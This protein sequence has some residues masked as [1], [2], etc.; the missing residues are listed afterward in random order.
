MTG[1]FAIMH[2]LQNAL[3]CLVLWL[4]LSGTGLLSAC[5]SDDDGWKAELAA[6]QKAL[7]LQQERLET[8]EDRAVVTGI[9]LTDEGYVADFSDGSCLTLLAASGNPALVTVGNDNLWSINGTATPVPAAGETE[10]EAP[11][12]AVGADGNW[13]LD[14][15]NTGLHA[16]VRHD[17]GSAPELWG[18]VET[19]GSYAFSFSDG[20]Q[21]LIRREQEAI[22]APYFHNTPLPFGQDSLRILCIGNSYTSDTQ[23]YLYEIAMSSGI[24]PERYAVGFVAFSA[25]SLQAWA[26]KYRS[27][28][29]V[30]LN[31][32]AGSLDIPLERAPLREI[33][34]QPWDVVVLQQFSGDAVDYST[35]NPALKQMIRY[36]RTDC[37][38]QRV[39]LA[40][41]TAWS[42]WSG[43]GP[44]PRGEER[45]R[46]ICRTTQE[47]VTRD[48]IDIIVPVGTAIQNAR[49][50]SL[51]TPY[52]LTRDGTHLAF[53]TGCYVA[54]CTWFQ[55]LM[56]P[57]FNVS[58]LGNKQL[59]SISEKEKAESRYPTQA[60]TA[61]N[62]ELCQRCAYYATLDFY[63][64][65]P[66]GE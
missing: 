39:A 2:R 35:F 1:M 14:G 61:E 33:L 55:A 38:N 63:N 22:I 34:R 29:P 40:W 21:V 65:T 56:A 25:A 58:I 54:A 10:G 46:Q 57:V 53:G 64:V 17:L 48:G 51:Q 11:E 4:A 18:I 23:L 3:R 49:H 28:E 9:R 41:Q 15:H 5:S 62:R 42:Y 7:T 12:L 30:T 8:L 27:G 43:Y 44:E 37:P 59:H 19:A 32:W 26:E 47:M 24:D 45:W 36:I 66:I 16:A 31:K 60:V 6:L 50:T 13:T 20:S 52:D